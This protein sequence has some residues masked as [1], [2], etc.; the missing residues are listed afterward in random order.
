[1]SFLEQAGFFP[2]FISLLNDN[3]QWA[4]PAWDGQSR[5]ILFTINFCL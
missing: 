5:T 3:P 4:C 2:L 1:M